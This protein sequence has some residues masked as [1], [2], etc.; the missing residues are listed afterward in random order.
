MTASLKDKQLKIGR[1]ESVDEYLPQII[2]REVDPDFYSAVSQNADHIYAAFC[3]GRVVGLVCIQAG[4]AAY[5]YVYIFPENR[6][7]G[8]GYLAALAAEQASRAQCKTVATSYDSNNEAARNLAC[9]CGFDKRHESV[10][11]AYTGDKFDLPVLPIRK[12]RDEDFFEAFTLSAEAFHVMRLQTGHDPN[13][14]PYEPDEEARQLCLQTAEERYVYFQGDEIIGC[15]HVD[16]AEIDNVAIRIEQQGKGYGR[17]FVK[18][19]TNEILDKKIGQP[20]L[21]CLLS[22][23]KALRLYESIGYTEVRRNT[24]AQKQL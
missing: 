3:E 6:N 4:E 9:K 2:C 17:S 21:F 5:A 24:Y 16:G 7:R 10:V 13:S 15:A 22:N 19:L 12:H 11:M 14:K 8:Y 18:Y 23:K 20:Y 1:V